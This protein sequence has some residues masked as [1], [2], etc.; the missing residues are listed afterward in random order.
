MSI[1]LVKNHRA[2]PQPLYP[3]TIP[4]C[5]YGFWVYFILYIFLFFMFFFCFFRLLCFFT[6]LFSPFSYSLAV[7]LSLNLSH[8]RPLLPHTQTPSILIRFQAR[9]GKSGFPQRPHPAGGEPE[10]NSTPVG[11]LASSATGSP[12]KQS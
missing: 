9:E 1:K 7:G 11:P 10:V 4:D 6:Y 12:G 8:S 2:P 5:L 3:Q